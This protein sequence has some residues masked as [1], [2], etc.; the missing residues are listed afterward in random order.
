MNKYIEKDLFL[1][2]MNELS[3][4]I[5][6][7]TDNRKKKAYYAMNPDCMLKYWKDKEY[8]RII[9]QED[10]LVYIDGMGIIFSQKLLKLPVGQERI[11]TTDLFPALLKRANEQGGRK[12]VY[13]LGSKGDTA[14]R[15]KRNFM[16]KY[17]NVNFVGTHHGYFDKK[18]SQSVISQINEKDVDI[19]FV[20]FGNPEQE[21][22]VDANYDDLK[23][24]TII[25]CGGLFDYYSNNVKRA[26]LF[27]QKIGMEWLFRLLQEPRRLF[28]R[29]VWG[30]LTYIYKIAQLKIIK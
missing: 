6:T 7:N 20:G 27:L 29:Y 3:S 28:K 1:G 10:N 5:L 18:D 11:A 14:E 19:L 2:T 25:T 17:P 22:W 16:W 21:K 26:P 13:L 4:H 30:N 15:V 12:R 24:T 9:N 23:V 8:N